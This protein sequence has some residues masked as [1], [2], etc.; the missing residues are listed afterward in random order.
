MI[1]LYIHVPDISARRLVCNDIVMIGEA[2]A[3][4]ILCMCDQAKTTLLLSNLS[5]FPI[6]LK[7]CTTK[8]FYDLKT[9]METREQAR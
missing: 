5:G 2:A 7:I 8:V 3:E 6:I 1:D 9:N 4:N